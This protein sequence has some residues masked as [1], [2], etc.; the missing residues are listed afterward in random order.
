MYNKRYEIIG[1]PDTTIFASLLK[2]MLRKNWSDYK[3]SQCNC[4]EN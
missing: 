2:E 3:H 1:E 4:L